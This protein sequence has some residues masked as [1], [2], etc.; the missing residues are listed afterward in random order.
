M[1]AETMLK[2]KDEHIIN[3]HRAFK[4]S[5]LRFHF[6]QYLHEEIINKQIYYLKENKFD[7]LSDVFKLIIQ[8]LENDDNTTE[9]QYLVLLISTRLYKEKNSDDERIMYLSYF[10]NDSLIWFSF[11]KWSRLFDY[12]RNKKFE[13][14]KKIIKLIN[15]HQSDSLS[16][17][18]K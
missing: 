9:E 2:S 1:L 11:E 17:K 10:I 16:K 14:N 3:Y 12:I 8:I 6:L 4:K 18:I 5:E 7:E 13:E 15:S